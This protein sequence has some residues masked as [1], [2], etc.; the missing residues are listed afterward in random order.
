MIRLVSF[1]RSIVRKWIMRLGCCHG[2]SHADAPLGA[3]AVTTTAVSR[4][5][6]WLPR[7]CRTGTNNSTAN[8]S[9]RHELEHLAVP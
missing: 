2:G 3:G 6:V 1:M 8:E 4:R 5:R 7:T 9:P